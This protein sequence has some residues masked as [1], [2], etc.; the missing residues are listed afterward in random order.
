MTGLPYQER[1]LA[2]PT[3]CISQTDYAANFADFINDTPEDLPFCFWYGGF[4][5]HRPYEYGT[6]IRLGG[7]NPKQIEKVPSYWPD[8]ETVLTDMLDYAYEIEHF[9]GHLARMLDLLEKQGRLHNTVV[10]VTADNGMPFPRVKGQ[11]YHAANHLPMAMMWPAGIDSPGRIV[12]TFVSF[13]DLA[14]TYLELAGLPWEAGG[15]APA[16]GRSLLHLLASI[17]SV[18]SNCA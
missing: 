11:A 12:E 16:E 15:M 7:K 13:S 10:V 14:P 4:E 18:L 1:K 5:P 8:N 6:G 2:P 9:D 17:H 3:R